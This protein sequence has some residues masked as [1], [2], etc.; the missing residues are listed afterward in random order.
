MGS[1]RCRFL[2]SSLDVVSICLPSLVVNAM[3]LV[4][5]L[6][7]GCS[8]VVGRS[9]ACLSVAARCCLPA[10]P[11][12]IVS[13]LSLSFVCVTWAVALAMPVASDVLV[14]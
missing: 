11:S 9:S 4:L 3:A 6:P 7:F 2:L 5:M 8:A 13:S 1:F 10:L 12:A 14:M